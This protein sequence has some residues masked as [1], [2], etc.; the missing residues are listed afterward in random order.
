[1]DKNAYFTKLVS[2]L[3]MRQGELLEEN[4]DLRS[5][6]RGLHAEVQG[7]VDKYDVIHKYISRARKT[8]AE[9]E[10]RVQKLSVEAARF[11]MPMDWLKTNVSEAL[12]SQLLALKERCAAIISD[13]E[14]EEAAKSGASSKPADESAVVKKLRKKVKDLQDIVM[15]QDDII[16][17]AIFTERQV[18]TRVGWGDALHTPF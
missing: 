12:F 2:S 3:E 18:R 9:E 15:Q 6:L 7:L 5:T 11:N 10:E 13:A 14:G 17:A 1:M 16:Q 4:N 8:E